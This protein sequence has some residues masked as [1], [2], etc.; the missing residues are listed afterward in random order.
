MLIALTRGVSL[1]IAECELTFIDRQCIDYPRAVQ[2]HSQYRQLLRNLGATVVELPSDDQCPDCCF[3][4]DTALVLDEVAVITRP[5]S[6]TRRREVD[7]VAP[8]I[9]KYRN[10]VRIDAPG[11]LEAGDV[12]RLGRNLFVGLSTR[13]NQQGIAMLRKALQAYGYEVVAIPMKGVLH[14]KSV[15]TALD[16]HTVLVNPRHFDA[17]EFSE[18]RLVAVPADES[19]AANVLRINGTVCMHAGFHQTADLLRTQG[20]DIKTVDISEFLKAEAGLTCMSITL[21]ASHAQ[22]T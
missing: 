6:E 1:R 7:G 9:M 22:M 16:D 14:L 12:L 11:T 10:V 20:F 2:Q 5:G 19:M 13:T 4:E 18:Y 15:C 17:A 21:Y 8:T 3:L